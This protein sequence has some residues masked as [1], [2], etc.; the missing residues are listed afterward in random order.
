MSPRK[1]SS[2]RFGNRYLD[3][4]LDIPQKPVSFKQ[5]NNKPKV[6]FDKVVIHEHA[7]ELGDNPSVSEGAPLTIA[8]DAQD[9]Q[10]Y[11]IEYYEAYNPSHKRRKSK[12]GLKL[13]VSDRAQLLLKS[14][15]PMNEIV[16]ATLQVL[17]CKQS[18]EE[19][20][21]N[22]KWDGVNAAIENTTRTLKK[23]ARRSS[24]L[25]AAPIKMSRR[26]SLP[27]LTPVV[28][29]KPSTQSSS[30]KCK[31]RRNS[32]FGSVPLNSVEGPHM[33]GARTA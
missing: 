31:S 14:G 10:T 33:D 5:S 30:D 24:L 27:S 17:E 12:N 4:D 1:P 22:M 18:R 11:E 26:G 28:M 29:V 20:I 13:S 2:E 15:Y 16:G 25:A 21:R 7:Y 3:D 23:V 6:W 8:W 32:L 9:K 19:S